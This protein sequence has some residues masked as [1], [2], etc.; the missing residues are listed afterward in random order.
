VSRPGRS[1][2]SLFRLVSID[3]EGIHDR[4]PVLEVAV[5]D[6][7]ADRRTEGLTTPQAT[8]EFDL[9]LLDLHPAASSVAVLSA[10]QLLLEPISIDLQAGWHPAEDGREAGAVALSR[11]RQLDSPHFSISLSRV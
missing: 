9:V 11:R 7:H 2:S 5:G 4:L 8:P 10:A 3:L 6:P 1:E